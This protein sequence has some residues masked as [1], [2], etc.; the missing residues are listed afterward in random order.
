[1]TTAYFEDVDA[2]K[3]SALSNDFM[4]YLDELAERHCTPNLLRRREDVVEFVLW[5]MASDLRELDRTVERYKELRFLLS[6]EEEAESTEQIHAQES[7]LHDQKVA[8]AKW[9]IDHKVP[10]D[11]ATT[12]QRRAF[13]ADIQSR[14]WG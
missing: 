4:A 14:I 9:L 11:L 7:A 5:C 6:S 3:L 1:M 12:E 13:W 2:Q 10:V 8:M